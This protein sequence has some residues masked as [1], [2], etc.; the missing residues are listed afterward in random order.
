MKM[1]QRKRELVKGQPCVQSS[2]LRISQGKTAA[3]GQQEELF[4][5]MGQVTQGG[6]QGAGGP[7]AHTLLQSGLILS[8]SPPLATNPR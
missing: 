6:W 5:G 7:S 3:L 4:P 8:L 1:G 2:G